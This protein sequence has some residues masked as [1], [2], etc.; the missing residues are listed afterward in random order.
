MASE[1]MTSYCGHADAQGLHMHY[2][3]LSGSFIKLE[4]GK[5]WH[6]SSAA[7]DATT[8]QQQVHAV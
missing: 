4:P 1:Q 3:W 6:C 7:Q 5:F 8:L 2:A